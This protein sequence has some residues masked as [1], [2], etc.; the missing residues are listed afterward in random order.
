MASKYLDGSMVPRQVRRHVDQ[1]LE[2]REAVDFQT[3]VLEHRGRRHT[4]EVL[5]LSASGAML[6]FSLIPYIGETIRLQLANRGQVC[7]TVCWVRDG[8]IGVSFDL[9][10]G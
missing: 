10:K 9:A 6:I 4:V 1:R 5:N 3:A 2:P 8:R 7:A